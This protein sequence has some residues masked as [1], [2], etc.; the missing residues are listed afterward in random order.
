MKAIFTLLFVLFLG[1]TV[2]AQS[3]SKN[4]ETVSIVTVTE[5][6]SEVNKEIKKDTKIVRLHKF[7]TSRVKKALAFKTKKNKTKLS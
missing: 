3:N 7:K 6:I 2:Q 5:T 4:I 1:V